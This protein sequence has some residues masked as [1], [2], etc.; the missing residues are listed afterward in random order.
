M[1]DEVKRK[2][3]CVSLWMLV[4]VPKYIEGS[5]VTSVFIFPSSVWN[6]SHVY[7]HA[8]P[9]I[10]CSLGFCDRV[11]CL[12]KLLGFHATRSVLWIW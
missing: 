3:I 5:K 9:L 10:L 6:L 11:G 12:Y 7:K 4:S 8:F 2:L 1:N